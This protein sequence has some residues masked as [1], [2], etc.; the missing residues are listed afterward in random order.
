MVFYGAFYYKYVV[1]NY[2]IYF[3]API[4]TTYMLQLCFYTNKTTWEKLFAFVSDVLLQLKPMK[5]M[6]M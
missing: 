4:S 2:G 6:S 5:K 1:I 3:G